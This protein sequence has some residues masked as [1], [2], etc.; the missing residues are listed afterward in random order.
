MRL[1]MRSH[2]DEGKREGFS[3]G[4]RELGKLGKAIKERADD[5]ASKGCLVSLGDAEGSA[6]L[7]KCPAGTP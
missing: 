5:L 7:Q 2:D 3:G 4:S 1:F 6:P